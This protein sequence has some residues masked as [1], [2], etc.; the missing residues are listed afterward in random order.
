MCGRF[1]QV[2]AME[3][4]ARHFGVTTPLANAPPRYN[5]APTQQAVVVRR[6]PRTGAR[7]L[8]LLRWGLVPSWASSLTIGNRMINARAETLTKSRAFALA[9]VKRRC[10]VPTNG[11]FEWRKS[12]RQPYLFRAADDA[13][14]VIAGLW[15]GWRDPASGEWI[16]TFTIVTTE[17]NEIAATVHNRMPA[18]LEPASYASWLGEEGAGTAEVL[19]LLKPIASARLKLHPVDQR[20]GNPHNDCPTLIEPVAIA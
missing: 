16:R 4:M 3:E 18:V 8:D 10:L 15:E 20:V 12:D 13:L 9:F 1:T 7:S 5:L 14:L 19:A 17:P 11:W 2:S 6:H